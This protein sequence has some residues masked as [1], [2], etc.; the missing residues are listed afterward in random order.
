MESSLNS[1][2][3]QQF[4][5]T[6]DMFGQAMNEC[7]DELWQQ[8]MWGEHSERP[9]LAEFWYVAYHALF[10]L[11]FYL[12]GD[13]ETFMPPEPFDLSEF[14]PNGLLPARVYAKA[15][16]R[17]YLD[18][19]REKCRTILGTLTADQAERRLRFNWG[20]PTYTELLIY[21]MRHVQEHGAQ[22][23][24]YLGQQ[25]GSEPGWIGQ[26]KD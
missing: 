9:D 2:L 26:A 23:R 13:A 21:N 15:E 24:M 17:T 3:W 8:S 22:M 16:L 7:P 11:D 20:E 4:G 14:D 6:I 18:Y 1:I 12:S 19:C 5:A 25:R 10:W